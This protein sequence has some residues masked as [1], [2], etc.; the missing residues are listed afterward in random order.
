MN[1][2]R[3]VTSDYVIEIHGR[4]IRDTGGT[5]G[6]RDRGRIESA[7]ELMW[8]G[9]GDIEFYPSL[10]EKAAMLGFVLAHDHGFVDG[11]KR[12]A[13]Q[14]MEY[15]LGVNDL[16]LVASL[17][18]GILAMESVATGHMSKREFTDWVMDHV[19]LLTEEERLKYDHIV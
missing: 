5:G 18:D 17:D 13:F 11:N 8:S 12:T 10:P 19:D 14:A 7:V 16:K 3:R 15:F 4:I 9:S 2:V 1:A 6:I